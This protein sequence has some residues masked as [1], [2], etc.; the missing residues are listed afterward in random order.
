MRVTRWIRPMVVFVC[1]MVFA[2]STPA[3]GWRYL[4]SRTVTDGQDHDTIAVTGTRGDFH[5]I[6]LAVRHAGV[7]FHRVVVHYGNGAD[8]ELEIRD[9]IPAGG[10]T[11]AIDLRGGDRVIQSV[12]FWYDA[13][14]RGGRKAVVSLYGWG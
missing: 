1:L 7:D 8:E 2:A 14:T 13:K 5:R 3:A 12:S 9:T 10:S 6:R 11:R 4:G